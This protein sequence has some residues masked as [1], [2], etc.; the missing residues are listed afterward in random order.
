M[1]TNREKYIN[2]ASNEELVKRLTCNSCAYH[3]TNKCGMDDYDCNEGKMLWLSQEA[4][5]FGIDENHTQVANLLNETQEETH[6]TMPD[7]ENTRKIIEYIIPRL[8]LLSARLDKLEKCNRIAEVKEHIEERLEE[9]TKD[10]TKNMRPTTQEDYY[11]REELYQLDNGEV[12]LIPKS[13]DEMFEELGYMKD[14]FDEL[15]ADEIIYINNNKDHI[16][17]R[18]N[19]HYIKYNYYNFHPDF[20][21]NDIKF[22]TE[23]EDK[24][25]HK[26]ISE[27]KEQKNEKKG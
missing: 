27:L 10:L 5:T 2:N 6:L 3:N 8:T 21:Y 13:A 22:I 26:K 9:E 23:A 4:E 11:E 25:I 19:G 20:D 16:L 15:G 17:V 18:K 14:T 7:D 24:A 1:A 12:K